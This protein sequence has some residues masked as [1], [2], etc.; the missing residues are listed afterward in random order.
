[1]DEGLVHR[2]VVERGLLAGHDHVDV[3]A[4]AQAVVG[5]GE[6][7]VGVGRQV[8]ADD[9]GLLVHHVVDEARILVR[10]TVVVLAP[11]MRGEQVVQ[12]GMGRRQ[13]M[14]RVTFNHLACWLNIESMMWMNAS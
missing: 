14:S 10:E 11:D 3:M 6:Q 4:A 1:M 9:L 5:D 13:G 12:G 8:D 2:E 7:A